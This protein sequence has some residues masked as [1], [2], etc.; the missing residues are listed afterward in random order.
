[1]ILLIKILGLCVA[2]AAC[3]LLSGL[4]AFRALETPEKRQQIFWTLVASLMATIAL[5]LILVGGYWAV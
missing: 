1:M 3:L 5:G 4:S 2:S